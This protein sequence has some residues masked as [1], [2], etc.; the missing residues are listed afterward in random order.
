MSTAIH[1]FLGANSG[2]GFQ[3]LFQRFCVPE[4]HYDLVVLKG[5]PGSGKSTMMKKIGEAMEERGEAVEYLHCSG[6]PDSLDGVHIPRIRTAVV[7]GTSPHVIEPRYP[8]AADRYVNLGDFYD[9]AAAKAARADIIRYTDACSAAYNRA[10]RAMSAAAQMADSAAA[11]AKEGLDAEKLM[12]R[13]DGIIA[14]EIRGKGSGGKDE[15]RFLGSMTCKGSVWRFDSVMELCPKIY[16]LQ[17]S[18]GL[19][20]PM[21]ERIRAAAASRDYRAIV[22][23]DPEHMEC[24]EHLLLPELEVAFVSSREGMN[25]D[26]PAYRRVRLDAMVDA[27]HYKRHKAR[28]RFSRKMVQTLREEALEALREAKKS[29]DALEA[30]YYPNVDFDG[31]TALTEREIRRM[32]GYL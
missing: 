3:N 19:A 1:F 25:Y 32:E 13:T 2:R 29:H 10:Y 7:D 5:G 18:F 12:R 16:Q 23:P 20:A 14:R 4:D 11:L 30:V 6:D 17:D 24:I 27:G 21:L 9:I 28:L 26:G 22:C 8:A 15:Y 31:V